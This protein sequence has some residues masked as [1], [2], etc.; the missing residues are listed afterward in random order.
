MY[1]SKPFV[2]LNNC[3]FLNYR[4][5]VIEIF[6]SNFPLAAIL[7]ALAILSTSV[8]VPADLPS[9]C[10]CGRIYSP[11]CASDWVTSNNHCEFMCRA[12]FMKK[13]FGQELRVIKPGRC[14]SSKFQHLRSQDPRYS[15][16][17][18]YETQII[19]YFDYPLLFLG[20]FGK[21]WENDQTGLLIVNSYID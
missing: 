19:L 14:E 17:C 8:A 10:A 7:V 1:K 5:G 6:K 18:R 16:Y 21:Q 15:K 11:V 3:I 4:Y 12:E 2:E 9:S 13:R 20:V